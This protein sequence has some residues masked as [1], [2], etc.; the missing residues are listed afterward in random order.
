MAVAGE[1]MSRIEH[2]EIGRSKNVTL[3]AQRSPPH[4]EQGEEER[5]KCRLQIWP[6]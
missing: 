4:K 5:N 1:R 6:S 3:T 2:K